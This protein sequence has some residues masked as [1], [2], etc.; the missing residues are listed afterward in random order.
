MDSILNMNANDLLELVDDGKY[1]A[2]HPRDKMSLGIQE[3]IKE[4]RDKGT[5]DDEIASR[6]FPNTIADEKTLEDV[7]AALVSG[8]NLLLFGPPGTGK[9][10]LAKDIEMIFPKIDYAILGCPV[11]DNPISLVDEDAYR[12]MKPC[13]LCV[14]KYGGVDFGFLEDFRPSEVDPSKIPVRKIRFGRG[15]GMTRIDGNEDVTADTLI[16]TINISKLDEVSDPLSPEIFV[17]GL[18]TQ[19]NNGFA[20]IDEIGKIRGSATPPLLQCLEED[21]VQSTYS[22]L[23]FP[24]R[25]FMVSTSNTED[26]SNISQ[27]LNDRLENILFTYCEDHKKNVEIAKRMWNKNPKKNVEIGI[28]YPVN[29]HIDEIFLP[30]ILLEVSALIIEKYRE[31]PISEREPE[32][33][34]NRSMG[35]IPLKAAGYALLYNKRIIDDEILK[36]GIKSTLEGRSRA[37]SLGEQ[38]EYERNV[39]EFLENNLP[40]IYR[41][42]LKKYW[43]K[44]YQT[45]KENY[46]DEEVIDMVRE[47]DEILDM[48]SGKEE[49]SKKMIEENELHKKFF[50][51][52]TKDDGSETDKIEYYLLMSSLIRKY[53]RFE[54]HESPEIPEE[55]P[56]EYWDE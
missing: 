24:A 34:S 48:E 56:V 1:Q 31:S 52:I 23:A 40:E 16:G 41:E 14:Q 4:L 30:G 22:R 18:L 45:V 11:Q 25:V 13:P 35:T 6:I 26:L 27:P 33:G 51:Y 2:L 15:K 3:R 43:C 49:E 9:T 5:D 47:A 12:K 55:N 32:G 28:R 53:T 50:D 19:A 17:P 7:T 46:S 8:K 54:C 38:K 20:L 37:R 39:D 42:T 21:H 44:F 10:L 36:R 29:N